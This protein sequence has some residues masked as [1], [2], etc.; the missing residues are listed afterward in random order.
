MTLL[1]SPFSFAADEKKNEVVFENLSVIPRLK[2]TEK[3]SLKSYSWWENDK[4]KIPKIYKLLL[5]K[6]KQDFLLEQFDMKFEI[7]KITKDNMS[8][9]EGYYVLMG[10]LIVDSEDKKFHELLELSLY[11]VQN[12]ELKLMFVS[13]TGAMTLDSSFRTL[14]MTLKDKKQDQKVITDSSPTKYL[15]P[16][17]VNSYLVV[18]ENE[19]SFN[20]LELIKDKI[21]SLLQLQDTDIS[22]LYS[23]NKKYTYQL[24]SAQNPESILKN[25]A[26]VNGPYQM[27]SRDKTITFRPLPDETS[28][29][30]LEAETDLDSEMESELEPTMENKTDEL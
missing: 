25:Q 24:K 2:L 30:A 3:N 15:N 6:M 17:S 16:S 13:Q 4:P 18:F 1:V 5:R 9:F 22:L 28:G 8:S 20:D 11:K 23:E 14:A 12:E 21:Q 29:S 26:F 27:V 7:K 19:L 10:N